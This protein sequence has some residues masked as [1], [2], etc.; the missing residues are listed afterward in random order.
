MKINK[1][2]PRWQSR[3]NHVT[4]PSALAS[5]GI[6]H[7][8]SLSSCSSVVSFRGH[9]RCHFLGVCMRYS[10]ATSQKSKGPWDYRESL[11]FSHHPKS[12]SPL[13]DRVTCASLPNMSSC[14]LVLVFQ[15]LGF[16]QM[17]MQASLMSK[18]VSC[19]WPAI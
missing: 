18:Y 1:V 14:N 17:C 8:L 13:R 16:T 2:G 11:S 12:R 4:V 5:A 15:D 9:L 19:P 10:D 7:Y 3:F 6:P